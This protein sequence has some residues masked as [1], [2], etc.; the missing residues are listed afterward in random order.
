MVEMCLLVLEKS[1][2]EINL[3][4][5]AILAVYLTVLLS[6]FLCFGWEK[7]HLEIFFI[8]S[9]KWI[10][11]FIYQCVK[12]IERTSVDF[13]HTTNTTQGL[14]D[15]VLAL[16]VFIKKYAIWSIFVRLILQI[17]EICMELF[18]IL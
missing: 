17:G 4:G 18:L 7:E 9:K 14:E 3:N 13:W 8:E 16:I 2:L 12:L 6:K 1:K 15:V 10:I 5:F 11:F